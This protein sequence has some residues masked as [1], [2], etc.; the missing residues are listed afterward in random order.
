MIA[1]AA[2]SRT[3]KPRGERRW[4]RRQ[5]KGTLRV[6][7][8]LEIERGGWVVAVRATRTEIE[9]SAPVWDRQIRAIA[10]LGDLFV[11]SANEAFACVRVT[12]IIN[13]GWNEKYRVAIVCG[14]CPNG[15]VLVMKGPKQQR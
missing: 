6:G 4:Q 15:M 3:P 2:R 9:V 12:E 10:N 7:G 8:V 13:P 5:Y 14:A 11:V 1:S